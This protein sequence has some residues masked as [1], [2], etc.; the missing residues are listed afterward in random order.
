M[1]TT[2]DNITLKVNVDGQSQLDSLNTKLGNIDASTKS[3]NDRLTQ[4]NVRNIAYQ[5]Q[6]LAVQ[7]SM[8]TNAFIAL[9]QQLPQLLSGFGVAGAVIGA[10]AAIAI[11]LLQQ[12]LKAVGFDMRNLKEITKD[13]STEI[14]KY[15]ESQKNAAISIS[16]LSFSY[17]NLSEAAKNYFDIV[18]EGEKTKIGI[19]TKKQIQELVNDY[20]GLYNSIKKAQDLENL[21]STAVGK[22]PV[23]LFLNPIWN[24]SASE[25]IKA[26][27]NGLTIDQATELGKRLQQIDAN[28]PEKNVQ[29]LTDITKWLSESTKEAGNF[30][31][32]Y[33]KVIIPLQDA[34][35]QILEQT[36]NIKAAA[37]EASVFATSLLNIQNKYQP[38]INAAKRNFD[39]IKASRLEG[40]ER[41]AEYEKQLQNKT[42]QDGVDRTSELKA[43]RLRTEQE[44]NDKISDFVKSQNEAYRSA[45]LQ[46]T[47]KKEQIA[48]QEKILN[49]SE[50]G[51]IS[52]FNI[53]QLEQELLTNATNY[54]EALRG[55]A[56]QRRK[57]VIDAAQANK[58]EKDAA[59]IRKRTDEQ[60][61]DAAERRQKTFLETQNRII[62]ADG[63]RLE[64]FNKTSVLNEREKKNAQDI[65]NINEERTKQLIGLEQITDP[66]LRANKEKEINSIY[67]DRVKSIERQQDAEKELMG[68]Y[69]AGW[70]KAY[71]DYLENSRNA[72]DRAKSMF[73]AVTKGMEDMLVDFFKTGKFGWQNFISTILEMILRSQIQQLIAKFM[74][75]TASGSGGL[76]GGSIIPGF[77]ASGGPASSG[78]PYIVGESG[79]EMFV[80]NTSGTVIPNNQLQG[81]GTAVTYNINAV[82]ASS[83]KAMIAADPSFIYAVT[84]QGSKSIPARR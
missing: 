68:N 11:P 20:G 67:D 61:Y 82:D 24:A 56:E 12:G 59:D 31:R 10:V 77:L 60:A 22:K 7:L 51:R 44:V 72:F 76:F 55:I 9:G 35:K 75:P 16:S 65:F 29:V 47:T 23:D 39:Q 3:A 14:T 48:L 71:A 64:L 21:R 73:Q 2:V 52:S 13:L 30:E 32:V 62:E 4:F 50:E 34:N 46:N 5:I 17:G 42:A 28:A 40:A 54:E 63:R 15:Q 83:F 78:S 79:P 66:T 27:F 81:L 70:K 69:G 53:Y 36:R 45:V 8:G 26:K 18:A 43:F 19:D 33:E 74:A 37:E 1:A 58:L 80:P 41:I 38:D 49:L 6:D 25:V 57:N 84:M